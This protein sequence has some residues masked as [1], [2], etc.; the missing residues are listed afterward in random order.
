[1]GRGQGKKHDGQETV[2]E[3]LG[4]GDLR[5]REMKRRGGEYWRTH[6]GHKQE[7]YRQKRCAKHSEEL[8]AKEVASGRA[9]LA[10]RVQTRAQGGQGSPGEP[11]EETAP[12][13]LCSALATTRQPS[14]PAFL[15]P[16]A[17]GGDGGRH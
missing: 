16:Q 15:R 5:F 14:P 13:L 4:Y 8:S 9:T 11:W 12:T 1:M 2:S 10:L 6:Q 7:E 17:L 3:A